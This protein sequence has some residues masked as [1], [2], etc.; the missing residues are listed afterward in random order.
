MTTK[1]T[2]DPT[3]PIRLKELTAHLTALLQQ[4]EQVQLERDQLQQR[5]KQLEGECARLRAERSQL[6][7][8]WAD[9]QITEEELDR[10]SREP[11]GR[12][13]AELLERLQKA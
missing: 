11:G 5:V 1:T 12:S 6:L 4:V 9:T 8:A 10:R 13:L 2:S 7:H 3:L